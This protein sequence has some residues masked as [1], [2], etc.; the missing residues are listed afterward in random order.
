[1]GVDSESIH[2]VPWSGD[3]R[4]SPAAVESAV[5]MIAVLAQKA[6][7]D[8]RSLVIVAHS[9]GSVIAYYAP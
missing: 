5:G 3:L 4:E 8:Q 9:W 6:G 7:K 1:M 2:D